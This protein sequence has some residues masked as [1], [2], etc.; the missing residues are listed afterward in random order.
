MPPSI[1]PLDPNKDDQ[2]DLVFLEEHPAEPAAHA[3]RDVWR[4]MIIDDD[5]DVHSTTTFALGNLDMQQRP[6]EFVHAYSASQAREMLK[7]EHD[8]AVILLDVVMEQDDAGLHLVRYIR[9]TLKLADVRIILRTG[10]P[11]YAP[12]IDAIRDYDINDYKTKSELTRIK[13]FTTVTAAIRSYEQIRKISNSRRGLDQIVHASTELMSLHG[14]HNFAA[15]VL[16]QI[17]SLLRQPANGLLCVQ[18]CPDSG[19]HELMA[20]AAAGSYASLDGQQLTAR[21]EPRAAEAMERT[22]VERRNHY[23]NGCITL[24]FAGKASRAFVAF[25]M[26]DRPVTELEERLLEVFCSNVAVGLDNVELVSHLHNAAFYDQ[27]SKLPNR[28]RLVEILDAALAGPAKQDASLALVDLDHFAETNDAL[29]HQFG[30][31]LLLAVA[32][33]LQTCLLY[34]SPSPRDLSTSRMP[35]SA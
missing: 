15:G 32:E 35:S 1:T 16:A 34:T 33:R 12:E 30:D 27:L 9:E 6:L 21:N 3:S 17:A 19:C 18:E 10:Q 4:V 24:Y 7:H 8:I 13:L 26:V 5:E 25:M 31:L 23:G 11:G 22:L 20:M 2:D 14:V 29:G 28:T